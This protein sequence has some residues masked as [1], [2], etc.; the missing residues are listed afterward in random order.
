MM[1]DFQTQLSQTDK[2]ASLNVPEIQTNVIRHV[3]HHW[4]TGDG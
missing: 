3:L 4:S 2:L 1:V